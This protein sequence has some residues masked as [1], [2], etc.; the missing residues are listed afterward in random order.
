[1]G[2]M[3]QCRM[4]VTFAEGTLGA[5]GGAGAGREDSHSLEMLYAQLQFLRLRGI[6]H[7]GVKGGVVA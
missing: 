2:P 3:G 7:T 5:E 4:D 6:L 1:M